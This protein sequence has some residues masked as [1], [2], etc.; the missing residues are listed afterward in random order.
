MKV[1]FAAAAVA[2]LAAPVLLPASAALAA[3]PTS[4]ACCT[5]YSHAPASSTSATHGRTDSR[6]A[7]GEFAVAPFDETQTL[8]G[9]QDI[10]IKG[11]QDLGRGAGELVSSTY[12]G[13]PQGILDI[14]AHVFGFPKPLAY[15]NE[16]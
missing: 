2:A 1:R 16:G 15:M 13:G 5:T 6:N 3:S 12:I 14:P 7:P 11:G 9:Q 10:F 8:E 4:A